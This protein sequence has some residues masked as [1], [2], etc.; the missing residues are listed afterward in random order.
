MHSLGHLFRVVSHAA[1]QVDAYSDCPYVEMLVENHVE[2][3]EYFI[4]AEDH[5]FPFSRSDY[6][7]IATAGIRRRST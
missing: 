4:S 1:H 6:A 7:S 2:R 3:F 5:N